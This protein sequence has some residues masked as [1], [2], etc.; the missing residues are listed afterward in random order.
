MLRLSRGLV[1][2]FRTRT[3]R[4][5]N[6]CRQKPVEIKVAFFTLS[7][8]TKNRRVFESLISDRYIAV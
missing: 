8:D 1:T 2:L 4:L 3:H 6:F 7:S 5:R